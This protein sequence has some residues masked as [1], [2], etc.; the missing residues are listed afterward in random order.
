M[1]EHLVNKVALVSGIKGQDRSYLAELLLS[2]G[3]FVHGIIRKSSM[4]NT[5]RTDHIYGHERL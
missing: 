2:K 5:G 1:S 4:F 3:Y